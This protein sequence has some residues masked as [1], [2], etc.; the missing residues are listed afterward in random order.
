MKRLFVLSM[1][2]FLIA[3]VEKN[4]PM[5]AKNDILID[6]LVIGSAESPDPV[7]ERVN[8]LEKN[9]VVK[10]VVVLESFPVQIHLKAT[11]ETIQELNNIPRVKGNWD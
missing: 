4:Q 9:G 3:C 2:L 11:K 6:A 8:E 5:S 1:L 7:L 10:D